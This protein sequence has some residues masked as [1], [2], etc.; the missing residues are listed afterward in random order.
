MAVLGRELMAVVQLF[1]DPR[2]RG[3]VLLERTGPN[4]VV[5]A[6]VRARTQTLK[7][8]VSATSGGRLV[9]SC[10]SVAA[11]KHSLRLARRGRVTDRRKFTTGLQA[12]QNSQCITEIG[13]VC[14]GGEDPDRCKICQDAFFVCP[15]SSDSLGWTVAGVLDGH[16]KRG[17]IVSEALQDL[18]P[19]RI[20][21][22]LMDCGGDAAQAIK[23]GFAAADSA[24]REQ[25]P[26]DARVSG[27]A[28]VTALVKPIGGGSEGSTTSTWQVVTGNA[29]DSS[30]M[31]GSKASS[32]GSWVCQPLS[33]KNTS[34]VKSER[35]RIE[36]SGG[37]VDESGIVWVGPIGV[38]MTRVLG[39]LALHP[40]GVIC[41][42]EVI[43]I[44]V[45]AAPGSQRSLG[46]SAFILLTSDGVTDVFSGDEAI[47]F[48]GDVL[49]T[50]GSF[51]EAACALV[52]AARARWKGDQWD[53]Y[54]DD[55]T[56]VVI[57][58]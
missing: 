53:V 52:E 39:D 19:E 28:C 9:M 27:A 14:V 49:A 57:P 12:A 29:G 40:F 22:C 55:A 20:K 56:A 25:I 6:T 11:L 50:T 15:A 16:G 26:R 24:L 1:A 31:L 30:A 13:S 23:E 3:T 32:G 7:P 46:G 41:E 8:S 47:Q 43:A 44:E 5:A 54:I 21:Q 38:A 48:V 45:Q 58:L 51:Q 42:P 36:A 2:P 34:E 10:A 4:I 33:Q 35:A 18:L 37:R 17:H